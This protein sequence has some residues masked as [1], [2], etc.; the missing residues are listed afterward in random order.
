V[1]E[2]GEVPLPV[3]PGVKSCSALAHVLAARAAVRR[4]ATE[5]IRVFG[6]HV[7][8]AVSANLIWLEAGR[9][10]T[11][12]A[13]LPLYPGIVRER[14]IEAAA[15]L[16]LSLEEG[17]WSPVDLR[18]AEAAALTGSVRGVEQIATLAGIELAA[19]PELRA[20]ADEVARARLT[21][22]PP[23]PPGGEEDAI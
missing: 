8:E 12:A 1:L 14:A 21:D 23:V 18:R 5:A 6:G 2:D 3:L 7:T 20:L 17:R 4:S 11:P 13:D 15:A 10:R 16:G 22:A 9:L 19:P